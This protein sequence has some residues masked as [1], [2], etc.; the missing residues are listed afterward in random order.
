M[1]K[2]LFLSLLAFYA[3]Y[4]QQI[5]A[6]DKLALPDTEVSVRTH[7]GNDLPLYQYPASGNDL[8][9]W[10]GGSGWHDRST[11]LAMDFAKQGI[12]V[13][14]IDFAEA[15]MQTSGSNFLRNL[16][17]QYVADIVDAAHQRTGK[18]VVLFA[19]SYAA[20]PALRGATLWQQ[21]KTHHGKLLG[22]VLFSPDLLTGLPVLGKDPEYLPITRATN[23]PMMIYQ[24]G[25]HGSAKQFSRLVKELTSNNPNVFFNVLPGVT[26]VFYGEENSAEALGLLKSLP[27]KTGSLFKLF[28]T[29]PVQASR[30]EYVQSEQVSSVRPDIKLHG[31]AGNPLPFPIDLQDAHGKRFKLADYRGKIT[32]VNFWAT[33]CPPCVE[34]IPSLNRLR[35]QM[36]DQPFELI[37]INYAES[38]QKIREFLQRVSVQFPVLIDPNGK[39]SQQWNV[40]GFPSTFVIGKDGR[41]YYGVN[42]AIHWDTAEVI[43][44]LKALNR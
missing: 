12:E 36:Q 1:M 17:A 34:E 23:I 37:S 38:P 10:I 19:Q 20:I 26:S 29:L 24:G 31:F 16:D 40:I 3:S 18:R 14:Q 27:E 5:Y 30:T 6:E 9:I 41:I 4:S 32:V 22:A 8:V 11:Q 25:L 15:L 21:R 13:W 35:E 7:D 39:V 44:T 28:E 42:A 2:Y 33:W 43:N